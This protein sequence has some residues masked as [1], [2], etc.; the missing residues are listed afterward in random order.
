MA[1]EVLVVAADRPVD[2][3]IDKWRKGEPVCVKE[4][5]AVWGTSEGL[6]KFIRITVTNVDYSDA[7]NWEAWL[8]KHANARTRYYLNPTVVED[9]ILL[10]GLVQMT[11]NQVLAAMADRGHKPRPAPE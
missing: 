7:Q 4:S 1:V 6:P 2:E 8:T 9:I 3:S 11:R 10:G 5:P